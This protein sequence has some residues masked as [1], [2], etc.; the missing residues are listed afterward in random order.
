M[1]QGKR[2]IEALGR[3]EKGRLYDANDALELAKELSKTKFD[4][5]IE[6]ALRLGVDPRHSDQVVRGA[7]V[8]PNGTGKTAR[9]AVFAKGEKIR[10]AEEAGADFVGGEDLA[11]RVQN[12]WTGFDMAVATPDMMALVGRLGKILGPRGLMPNPRTGT[13]TFDLKNAIREIKAGKIEFRT[14]KAGIVHAPIGKVS[15]TVEALS[16]NLSVLL[17]AIQKA[18]PSGA[19]GTYIKGVT[20]STTM[21]PGIRVNPQAISRVEEAAG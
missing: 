10:E 8:L 14:E 4:E 5:T 11:E 3:V 15:F 16:E 21:G 2:Y 9:V 13:V 6:V 17:D 19:K 7:V 1:S 18:K 20:L 12:G